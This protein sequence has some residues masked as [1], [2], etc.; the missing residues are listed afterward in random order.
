MT[1]PILPLFNV[2]LVARGDGGI[3]TARPLAQYGDLGARLTRYEHSS[4][5]T[6]GFESATVTLITDVD[7]ALALL[8]ECGASTVITGPDAT[9]VF[10]GVLVTVDVRIGQRSRSKS[11]EAVANRVRCRYTTV[12]GT[13]AVTTTASDA[14]SVA[15]Y[16]TKDGV[17]T[18]NQTNSAAA[19]VTRNRYLGQ[20]AYPLAQPATTLATGDGGAGGAEVV[21]TFAGWY[22]TLGWV[23]LERADTASEA[24]TTQVGTLIGSGAFGIAATNPFLSTSTANIATTGTTAPRTIAADTTFRQA[25]ESRLVL[26]DTSDERFAWGVYEGRSLRVRQ[27]AG[28]NPSNIGYRLRL[29]AFEVRNGQGGL[30]AP[31]DVR[32]D[33]MAEDTDL[34]EAVVSGGATDS[35][36]RFYIE[37]VRFA[38]DGQSMTL[39]LEPAATTSLDARIARLSM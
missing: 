24:T 21:L 22:E 16:G 17:V 31:W 18:V 32:P 15:R 9:T 23:M 10:E 8:D 37:R 20:F 14:T 4:V 2:P 36:A 35:G 12:L 19:L 26:G 6:C 39:T 30:V 33:A 34:L 29:G 1:P 25:I 3:P 7:E 28:A 38:M 27:W 11:L 13:P 5:A